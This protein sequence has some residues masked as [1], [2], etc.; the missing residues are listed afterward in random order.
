MQQG[1]GWVYLLAAV[2]TSTSLAAVDFQPVHPERARIAVA[3]PGLHPE[4]V[5]A[6]DP[7]SPQ[8]LVRLDGVLY[9]QDHGFFYRVEDHVVT[10][11]PVVGIESW[12]ELVDRVEALDPSLSAGMR[13]LTVARSNRLGIVDLR[14]PDA[15]PTEWAARIF[16]SGLVRYAEVSTY[17]VYTD[18]PPDDSLYNQQWAL[19]NTGQT[20]GTPGADVHAE[21]AWAIHSGTPDVIVAILDSGTETDHADLQGNVWINED[22]IPGNGQDDDGNGFID[23]WEGWDFGNGNNDPDTSFYHGTHVTGIIN[24]VTDNGSGIAGLAGGVNGPG[25]R[26][27]ALA[28]GEF[29]PVGS[30]IDDAV[31]YAVDNGAV[32]ITLSLSVAQTSAIDDAV[33][34]AYT[35]AD[36]FLDCA[37]G[38]N[39]PSVSYPANNENLM[40]VAS[41]TDDDAKSGFSNP[42]PQVEVAAPGSDVLSTQLNNSYDTSSGTSFAAPYVAGLAALIR[43]VNPSL[44]AQEVRQLIIDSA[45]DVSTPG[46]DNGTGWGRIN[47]FTALSSTGSSNGTVEVGQS[48]LTCTESL[49]ITVADFDLAGAGFLNVTARSDTEAAGETVTLTETEFATF[50]GAVDL[51]QGAAA[52]DG[53]LQVDHEESI[54]VEYVD[55]DNGSGG[56]NVVKTANAATDCAGPAVLAVSTSAIDTD[57]VKI[58]WQIDEVGVGRVYYGEGAPDQQAQSGLPTTNHNATIVGLESCTRYAFAVSAFDG[59]G[60]ESIDDNGGEFYEFQTL[61]E[62]PGFGVVPCQQGMVQLDRTSY[63]CDSQ[64]VIAV[65]DIDLDQDPGSHDVATVLVASSTEPD[66]EWFELDEVAPSA[67]SFSASVPLSAGAAVPG[68]GAVAAGPGDLISV[69]YR[70]LDDGSGVSRTVTRTATADCTPPAIS[71]VTVEAISSTRA[72][73]VWTTDEPSTSRV[74]YGSEASLGEVAEDPTLTTNHRVAISAF[75]ACDRVFFRVSSTDEFGDVRVADVGGEPFALNLRQIGGLVY[76]QNFETDDGWTFEGEWERAAPQGLGATTSDPSA[77]YSGTFAIGNDLTGQGSYAG[78]YEPLSTE[79]AYSPV[80][81]ATGHTGLELIVRRKLGVG[82]A[83]TASVTVEAPSATTV[84]SSSSAINDADWVELRVDISAVADGQPAVSLGFGIESTFPG[85]GA[86]WNVDELIVKEAAAPDY[87]VCGGCLGA[88]GFSGVTDVVDPEPCAPGGLLVSWQ[89]ASA[90]GTGASGTYEVYRGTTPDFVPG[91]AN[92]IAEELTGTSYLDASAPVDTPVWYVVRARNDED[93]GGGLGLEDTNVMRVGATETVAQAA[94]GPVGGS[95]TLRSLG[96]AHVRIDW[97]PAPGAA[98]YVVRRATSPDL[99][100][101]VVDT[102]ITG[103][104]FE[105]LDA[106]VDGEE[107]YAYRVFAVNACGVVEGP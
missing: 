23:D 52:P 47:A 21:E 33:E 95:V 19:N 7:G 67:G 6:W 75:D 74:D 50:T 102:E 48:V 56:I 34:L 73:I 4:P 60:N 26:G 79:F 70:D 39:G 63:G 93:C 29:G 80:F 77:A 76:H 43:G 91:A 51:A 100:T 42:G 18:V 8:K 81:D 58:S 68:D 2:A 71:N 27:M 46:F 99:G 10:V 62:F 105:D 41:T 13:G 94:P 101:G 40:A 35:E 64:L 54:S 30:V 16:A 36:V 97:D 87:P 78:S 25:V 14:V 57:S 53:I 96:Q 72:E 98:S 45:D 88:P 9:Q 59:L 20:G 15:D 65:N 61:G 28:V 84:W 11:R 86:G 1:R 31:L 83:D 17:G 22:E 85:V 5:P 92:R 106:L 104:R 38:N 3:T 37:S 107:F 90:W 66:G 44:T 49:T 69:T 32:V 55:A 24:A 89:P 103:A 12:D 82:A